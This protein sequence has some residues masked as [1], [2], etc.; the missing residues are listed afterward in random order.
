MYWRGW[1][2]G[3]RGMNLAKGVKVKELSREDRQGRKVV[4]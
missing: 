4:E 1:R 2:L 3:E